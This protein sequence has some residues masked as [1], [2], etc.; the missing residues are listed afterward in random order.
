MGLG[1]VD[2]IMGERD[3]ALAICLSFAVIAKP[4][5]AKIITM[6]RNNFLMVS[7]CYN[8]VTKVAKLS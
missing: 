5:A 2:R 7:I 4:V 1:T 3:W 6:N 8:P